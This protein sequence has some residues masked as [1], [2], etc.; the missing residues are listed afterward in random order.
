MR[1]PFGRDQH[2][3]GLH[4]DLTAFE[5]EQAAT[6]EDVVDLVQAGVR[7]EFVL[8][9]GLEAVQADENGSSSIKPIEAAELLLHQSASRSLDSP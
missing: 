8:L 7:V 3:A 6:G 1:H 2:N 9:A 5:Q 4:R